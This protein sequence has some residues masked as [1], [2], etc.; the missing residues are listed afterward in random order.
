MT[1]PDRPVREAVPA[2]A[3]TAAPGRALPPDVKQR[4]VK[5]VVDQYTK[6]LSLREVADLIGRNQTVVRR[7][8]DEAG[9][10]RRPP[11]APPVTGH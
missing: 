9:I 3:A 6:G 7:L 8:L 10:Q 4:L 11:G 1:Y 5:F 2:F